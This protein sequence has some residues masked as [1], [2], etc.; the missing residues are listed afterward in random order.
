MLGIGMNGGMGFLQKDYP[1]KSRAA[2][3]EVMLHTPDGVEACLGQRFVQYPHDPISIT[4][5]AG[6]QPRHVGDQMVPN[7]FFSRFFKF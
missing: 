1:R 3:G 6:G 2:I 4:Q 5:E 7:D